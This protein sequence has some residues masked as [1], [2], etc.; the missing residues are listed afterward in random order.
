MFCLLGAEQWTPCAGCSP[1]EALVG[2]YLVSSAC[3]IYS[4]LALTLADDARQRD[5]AWGLRIFR[6][7][8]SWASSDCLWSEKGS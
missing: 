1:F 8:A 2:R 5:V 4:W 3:L 6:A 7:L